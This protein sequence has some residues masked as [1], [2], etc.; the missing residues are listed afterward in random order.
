MTLFMVKGLLARSLINISINVN[1]NLSH[2]TY[3]SNYVIHV[4]YV[5][6][7]YIVIMLYKNR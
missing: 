2:N 1:R 6:Y 5:H 4:N 3:T 7:M